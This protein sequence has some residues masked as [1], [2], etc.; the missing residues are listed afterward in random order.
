MND[1]RSLAV[2]GV[3]V[4]KMTRWCG[5]AK[6]FPSGLAQPRIVLNL[7]EVTFH[8]LKDISYKDKGHKDIKD[9]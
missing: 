6:S 3:Q 1:C 9:M 5:L 2:L 7:V 8:L 4:D